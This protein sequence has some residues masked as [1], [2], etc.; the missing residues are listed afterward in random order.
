[1]HNLIPQILLAGLLFTSVGSPSL[2]TAAIPP[3]SPTQLRENADQIFTGKVLSVTKTEGQS[4][5]FDDNTKFIDRTYTITISVTSVEKSELVLVGS[6]VKVQAWQPVGGNRGSLIGFVGPQGHVPIPKDGDTVTVYTAKPKNKTDMPQDTPTKTR[7]LVPLLPNGMTIEKGKPKKPSAPDT[8]Q[9][10]QP[11]SGEVNE[12]N[13]LQL[14]SNAS[15]FQ[16]MATIALYKEMLMNTWDEKVYRQYAYYHG[17][18]QSALADLLDAHDHD[19]VWGPWLKEKSEY[20]ASVYKTLEPYIE[21]K[22]KGESL[23]AQDIA[24]LT[25]LQRQVTAKLGR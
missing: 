1:M 14:F 22:R 21:K 15:S 5:R 10:P 19:K 18:N 23:S 9:V 2:A 4:T 25:Q 24:N 16:F 11:P 13:T 6:E 8:S 20:Q 17:L 3:L 12:Q 7:I